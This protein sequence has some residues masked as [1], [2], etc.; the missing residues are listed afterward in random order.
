MLLTMLVDMDHIIADPIY[1][2]NRCSIGFHPLHG[3]FAAGF[4]LAMLVF[5]RGVIRIVGFGLLYHM[6][7]D[8]IDCLFM[9]KGECVNC[10]ETEWIAFIRSAFFKLNP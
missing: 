2:P 10:H 9:A 7:T 6:F 3:K 5:G 8:S 1:N 4:Y